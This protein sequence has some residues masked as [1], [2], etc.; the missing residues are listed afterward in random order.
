HDGVYNLT[1]M[2]GGTEELWFPEWEFKG[3]PWTNKALYE[4]LSPH[5]YVANFKTPILI[6]HGELD[7][8]VPIGEGLQLFTA[9]QRRGVDSKLLIF[10]DEGHWVLKPLNSRLWHHTVLGWL[11]KYLKK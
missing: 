3:T 6:I 11:D 8:R 1:S 10:P 4:R 5:N 7:Y 9:V 2:Y